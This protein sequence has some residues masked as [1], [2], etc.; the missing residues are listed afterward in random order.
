MAAVASDAPQPAS[1]VVTATL[2]LTTGVPGWQIYDLDHGVMSH[3]PVS[4]QMTMTWVGR[5]VCFECI[6]SKSRSNQ[7]RP[8]LQS[9]DNVA[10]AVETSR[11][12]RP[13]ASQHGSANHARTIGIIVG[14]LSIIVI[15]C[16][17]TAIY[18]MIRS[19][20]RRQKSFNRRTAELHR[21]STINSLP[22][23]QNQD[24]SMAI[25]SG[26]GTY[27]KVSISITLWWMERIWDCVG[28]WSHLVLFRSVL[29]CYGDEYILKIYMR[30][31]D[32]K[33]QKK[34]RKNQPSDRHISSVA[35]VLCHSHN[36]F[37]IYIYIF[38]QWWAKQ[39]L[40]DRCKVKDETRWKVQ[41]YWS[42]ISFCH[43][44]SKNYMNWGRTYLNDLRFIRW[45]FLEVWLQE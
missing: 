19:R 32:I 7:K 4:G 41:L 5:L 14:A 27:L 17:F 3:P 31:F 20:K 42:G 36:H 21:R 33:K 1:K 18:F 40:W 9:L 45:W 22:G 37:H 34:K 8:L 2:A 23:H 13:S 28:I 16:V 24:M 29:A 30:N 26:W 6:L 10:G 38:R 43:C 25:T 15:T 39:N 35:I 12:G 44:I 11:S